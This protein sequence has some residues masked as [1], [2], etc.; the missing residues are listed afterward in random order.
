MLL[1]S[2][3]RPL[4]AKR[5]NHAT[6]SLFHSKSLYNTISQLRTFPL[7]ELKEEHY[8]QLQYQLPPKHTRLPLVFREMERAKSKSA[9]TEG[10]DSFLED[11]SITQTTLDEVS[12]AYKQL[13][14]YS[15]R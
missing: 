3:S 11:Y 7:A 4:D 15:A 13:D 1:E 5:P 10:E 2:S 6:W 14:W 12:R 9:K 8:N